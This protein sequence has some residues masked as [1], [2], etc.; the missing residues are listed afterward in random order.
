[1]KSKR[2]LLNS[3]LSKGQATTDLSISSSSFTGSFSHSSQRRFS[4][5]YRFSTSKTISN[6]NNNNPVD[7]ISITENNPQE[8]LT[9]V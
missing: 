1:M 2:K 9:A 8:N 5:N 6:N 3:I 4:S 7:N